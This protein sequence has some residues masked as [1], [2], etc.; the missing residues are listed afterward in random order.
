MSV[1]PNTQWFSTAHHELG[2][3]YYY[4]SYTRPEVPELLRG[5]ANRAFHEG[6]GELIAIAG[7]PGPLPAG[8][9]DP[10]AATTSID[11]TRW[12][13]DEALVADRSVP[14]LVGGDDDALGARPVQGR[15]L[16]RSVERPLVGVRARSTRGWSPPRL[17]AR[18]C[19]TP[20]RRPT[21]TTTRRST[22]TTPSR[23]SSSTSSTTTSQ[24]DPQARPA[25]G[26]LLRAQ[27]RRRLPAVDPGEGRDRGLARGH[28]GRDGRGPLHRARCSSTSRR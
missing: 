22:T 17:A 1:Q 5:G 9:G 10:R 6:I 11:E 7:E 25:P 8:G 12:L 28:E 19:A 3:V 23:R 4:L 24:E 14:P 21:S 18:S 26:E 20:P 27:G 13:L 15:A 2:H 16:A